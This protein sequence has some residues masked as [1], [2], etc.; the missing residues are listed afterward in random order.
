M[1]GIIKKNEIL[2]PYTS[3]HIGGPAKLYFR[4]ESLEN[5]ILFLQKYG[6]DEPLT[7]LGLGSNVLI[8]D[9]GLNHTVIHLRGALQS[10]GI[11]NQL[12]KVEAGV[13]CAKLTKFCAKNN[14]MEAEFFA[15][16]PG[17][18]G[19]ALKMNA[20]AWGG[21]TWDRLVGVTLINH[22]GEL[23][24]KKKSDFEIDYRSVKMP[25]N[26]WF[27]AA[28]FDFPCG[29]TTQSK[30]RIE[31]LLKKRKETQPIGT[32]SCGSVFKNPYPLSAGQLIEQCMLK[33]YQVGDAQISEK[34]ANFIINKGKARAQDVITLMTHIINTVE[35]QHNIKLQPEVCFLGCKI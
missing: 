12:L 3:W 28:H 27:V 35:H 4:P 25:D 14:F 29:D 11:E 18:I 30:V 34:H 7:W 9:N 24:Y 17:T 15:G 10:I 22:S 1:R 21:N 26:E 2:A 20:G 6:Q 5:L 23:I 16:I 31:N 8:G 13:S 33:G 19:G 32:K